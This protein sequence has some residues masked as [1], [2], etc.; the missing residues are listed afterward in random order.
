MKLAK[1]PKPTDLL[2]SCSFD[3]TEGVLRIEVR[4]AP[5]TNFGT[6]LTYKLTQDEALDLAR[7]LRAYGEG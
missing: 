6:A 3:E 7:A 4:A 5:P 1:S 2:L